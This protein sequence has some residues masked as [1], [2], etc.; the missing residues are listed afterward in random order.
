MPSG[1]YVRKIGI[2]YATSGKHWKIKDTSNMG[3][4]AWNK[5]KGM[6]TIKNGYRLIKVI[7]HPNSPADGYVR[8]HRIVMENRIGRYL[9]PEEIVH[10]ING[11]KLDNRIENLKLYSSNKEH[12]NLEHHKRKLRPYIKIYI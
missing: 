6:G 9:E 12:E 8:E 11:N 1:V 3:H 10:H 5:G 4:I 7:C 2:I